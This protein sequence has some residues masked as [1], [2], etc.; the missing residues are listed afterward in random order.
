MKLVLSEKEIIKITK[1]LGSEI[2]KEIK[3]EKKIPVVLGIM[4]GALNFMQD[5]VKNIKCDVFIDYLQI[6]SYKGTKSTNKIILKK[7][8]DLNIKDRV[9]VLVEDVIET[10]K[11]ISYLLNL[12]KKDKPK[13]IILVILFDKRTKVDAKKI[14]VNY[15]GKKLKN[16]NFLLGYGFDLDELGRNLPAIY[17]INNVEVKK[18]IKKS[19]T[20]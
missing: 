8:N 17:E 1:K 6:S 2:T 4:K 5:V 14:K 16:K 19:Q 9:V 13:K 11:S 18:I 12:L 20:C 7:K 10:G 15:I 3:N